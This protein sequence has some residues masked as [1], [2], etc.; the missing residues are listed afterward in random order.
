MPFSVVRCMSVQ[1]FLCYYVHICIVPVLC[2][3]EDS[4]ILKYKDIYNICEY[5]KVTSI[6][7]IFIFVTIKTNTHFASTIIFLMRDIVF[8][9]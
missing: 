6:S 2:H 8:F 3:T 4:L 1:L 9:R 7:L 5:D